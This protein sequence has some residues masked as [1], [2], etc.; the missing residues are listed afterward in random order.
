MSTS[1]NLVK[2]ETVIYV[3]GF[4]SIPTIEWEEDN[5]FLHPRGQISQSSFRKEVGSVVMEGS[6]AFSSLK[7]ELFWFL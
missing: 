2:R 4:Q 7:Q 6:L 3:E 5:V 1:V